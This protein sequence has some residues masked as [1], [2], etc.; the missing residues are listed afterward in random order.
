MIKVLVFSPHPDDDIIGCG[1]SICKHVS[2]GNAVGVVYMTSGENGGKAPVPAETASIREAE[3]RKAAA[4]LGI[5]QVH[6]L[7]NPDGFL[8]YTKEN[9]VQ[10]AALLREFK[11]TLIYMPHKND[12]HR[13]HRV[14]H[15][16]VA[17]ACKVAGN[18]KMR[19]SGL[20][21]WRIETALCYEISTPMEEIGYVED[22]SDYIA[23]KSRALRF[24]ASQL[25]NIDYLEAVRSLNRFRGVITGKGAYCECFQIARVSAI[26]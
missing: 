22:I 2:K 1:G 20:R 26:V 14:T 17:D 8:N 5:S 21:P 12:L 9:I 24:H 7:K 23:A 4:Y 16:L 11:P 10:I 19:T 15:D 18:P 6:F 13:D 3:A 25:A